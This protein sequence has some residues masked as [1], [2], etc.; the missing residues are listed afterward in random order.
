[1]RRYLDVGAAV[2]AHNDRRIRVWQLNGQ[3]LFPVIAP[4]GAIC[5]A[6]ILYFFVGDLDAQDLGR[7]GPVKHDRGYSWGMPV[8]S[9]DTL[10]TVR[11]QLQKFTEYL[12]EQGYQ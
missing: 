2:H 7:G 1:M 10:A 12:D 4:S 9:E 5:A 11:N 8:D 6:A 3:M